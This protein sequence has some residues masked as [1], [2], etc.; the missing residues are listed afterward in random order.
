VPA[1]FVYLG[2]VYGPGKTFAS[3]VFPRIARGRFA[4]PGRATNRFPLIHVRDAAA[5][6]VHL[7]SL[8]PKRLSGRSWLLVDETGGAPLG[9]FFDEAARCL[10]TPQ[11]RRLPLWLMS[12]VAGRT[13]V[14]TLT[15]DVAA[16]PRALLETGFRF[17]YPTPREGLPPTLASLGYK[18][19]APTPH[20]PVGNVMGPMALTAAAVLAVNTQRFPLSVPWLRERAGGLPILDMRPGYGQSDV[21]ALLSALGEAGRTS[22]LTMLWTI[23]L[24]LP[25]LFTFVLFR[26]VRAGG[27]SRW[28]WLSLAPGAADYLEN[29]AVSALLIAGPPPTAGLVSVASALTLTKAGLY[30][31][32]ALLAAAGF[33]IR[34][35]GD[36]DEPLQSRSS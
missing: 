34:R 35:E 8:G 36:R 32:A 18:M 24:V 4:L 28:R 11:P 5:A 13:L 17:T 3:S 14:E 1:T 10:G 6:I 25:A 7:A 19:P 15:R 27:L 23:D 33:W 30:F 12:L 21:L 2:T 20:R 22:Y 31:A 26:A 16:S 29:V 9:D